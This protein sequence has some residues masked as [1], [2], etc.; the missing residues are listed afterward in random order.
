MKKKVKQEEKG[1]NCSLMPHYERTAVINQKQVER[2]S[3]VIQSRGK[4][5][6]KKKT[7]S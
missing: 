4:K 2:H 1:A 5:N 3:V 6:R 7:R